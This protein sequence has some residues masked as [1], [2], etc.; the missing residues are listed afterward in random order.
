MHLELAFLSMLVAGFGLTHTRDMSGLLEPL[1]GPANTI[2]FSRLLLVSIW[3]YLN[4][5]FG[6]IERVIS[7][8][9]SS[10]VS[11]TSPIPDA[12]LDIC[13]YRQIKC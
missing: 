10:V 11:P 8:Y 3:S 9:F 2:V 12:K 6:S 1:P 4:F 5:F 7:A 13:M